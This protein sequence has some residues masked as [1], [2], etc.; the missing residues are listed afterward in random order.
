[1]SSQH[2]FP[3]SGSLSLIASCAILLSAGAMSADAQQR[4]EITTRRLPRA[5]LA[6]SHEREMKRLQRELDSL[7]NAYNDGEEFTATDRRRIERDLAR[8]VEHLGELSLRMGD[9]LG[10]RAPRAGEMIRLR[11]T[12]EMLNR[13]AA[14]MSRALMQV[15]EAQQAMPKGWIGIV[16]EGPNM[17]RIEDGELVL[18]YFSYPRIVSVDPSSPAQRAGL[19]PSDTLLAYD[20]RDVRENDIS[21]T[22]LLRPNVKVSVRVRRDGRV[23]DI[24]VT[25]AVAPSR[26]V[27]RRDGEVREM[28]PPWSIAGVPEPA[29]V[30]R[31]PM[32][33]GVPSGVQSR[34][35][36]RTPPR[37]PVA[38]SMAPPRGAY[39]FGFVTN[40]VAGAQLTTITP[41]LGRAIGVAD[42]VLVTSA[43]IGSPA[44]ESGLSDG[45]VIVKVGGQ[46]VRTVPDVRELVALAAENGD[47]AIELVILRQKRSQRLVLRW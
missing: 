40:G 11:R 20:G 4:V 37:A 1:M 36:V 44:N 8:A 28:T 29:T 45:D 31:A 3:S 19:I 5:E 15:K 16:A 30:P 12:P 17:T 10:A 47:H 22:R 39:T 41:G 14:A 21:L 6:D 43:P 35:T 13:S 25:V 46:G 2:P 26:I 9:D 24:P 42:G 18:R 32:M 34:V 38:P 33:P 23:R 27:E 7:S